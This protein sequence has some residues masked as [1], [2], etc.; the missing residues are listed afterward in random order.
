MT[1]WRK[2][3]P[4]YE[5][6]ISAKNHGSWWVKYL[7]IESDTDV[8]DETGET[9]TWPEGWFTEVVSLTCSYPDGDIFGRNGGK[10]RLHAQGSVIGSFDVDDEERTKNLYWQPVVPPLDDVKD[11]RPEVD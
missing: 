9:Y 11:T 10:A 3:P 2:E 8:D 7:L 1:S 6:W 5:E 4:T